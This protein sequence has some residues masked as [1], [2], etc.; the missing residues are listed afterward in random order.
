VKGASF[1]GDKSRIAKGCVFCVQTVTKTQ[2]MC[3][4]NISI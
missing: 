3:Y 1:G 2:E 4:S